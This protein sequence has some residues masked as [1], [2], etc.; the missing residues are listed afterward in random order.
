M[1][2]EVGSLEKI[3]L[4]LKEEIIY[5]DMII[6]CNVKDPKRYE[7]SKKLSHI[8]VNIVRSLF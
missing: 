4:G 3:A 5:F 7:G 2:T 1:I 6:T 8:D